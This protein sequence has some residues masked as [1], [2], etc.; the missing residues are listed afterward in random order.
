MFKKSVFS[1]SIWMILEKIVNIFGLIFINSYMAK[2]IGPEN[3]GKIVFVS[4][5]FVFIQTFSFFGSQNI[6]FKRMVERKKSGILLALLTQ[7]QRIILL[8]ISSIPVILYLYFFGNEIT[9][10]FGI[11]NLIASYF[12]LLDIFSIY[13]NS[14]L[15]SYINTIINSISLIII[16]ALR[17]TFTY[18]NFSIYWFA[19]PIFVLPM[20]QY[21]LRKIYFYKNFSLECILQKNI[22]SKNKKK[23]QKYL[24]M[25]GGS[26][27]LSTLSIA[28]YGQISNLFLAKFST[29]SDL[30][31]YSISM[32][33][34][35]A[36][37]FILQALT[38]SY[39]TKIY[40]EKN[41]ENLIKYLTQINIIIILISIFILIIF[42]LVGEYFIK[43]LYGI[44]YI[45][46]VEIIPIIIIGTMFSCLGSVYYRYMIKESGYTYLSKKMLIVG[47]I[48]VPVS[49]LFITNFGIY[50]AAYCYILIELIS[51]SIANY[52]F[53]NGMIF[54]IHL[55]IIQYFLEFKFI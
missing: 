40:I 11:A 39:F 18:F 46:A 49:Y 24:F 5:L 14:Q 41:E 34:G 52:F 29:L 31:I 53:K 2:Y 47:L 45:K 8:I 17:F 48:S 43:K 44:D 3:F 32:V 4:T 22:S 12:I 42:T 35:G 25:T 51:F 23:Y 7:N 55:K 9:F 6:L 50:G 28:L 1:N 33:L 36:W 20:F 13:N 27:L 16:L 30:G 37:S 19:A 38:T 54:K 26:L 21:I 15:Y 10:F